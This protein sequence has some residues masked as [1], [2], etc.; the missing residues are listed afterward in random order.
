[1]QAQREESSRIDAV[2]SGSPKA[3]EEL[4]NIGNHNDRN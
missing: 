2:A 1:M 3:Q 4:I